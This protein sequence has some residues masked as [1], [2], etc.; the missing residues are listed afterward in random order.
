MSKFADFAAVAATL[1]IGLIGCAAS[2]SH[3]AT[4]Q[5]IVESPSLNLAQCEQINI[6]GHYSNQGKDRVSPN[7]PINSRL[8]WDL[9]H[10]F[11][12]DARIEQKVAFVKID[13]KFPNLID[14]IASDADGKTIAFANLSAEHKDYSCTNGKIVI[15][16]KYTVQ[17]EGSGINVLQIKLSKTAE[18][19]LELFYER[20]F[21]SLNY[22]VS[23]YKSRTVAN[24]VFRTRSSKK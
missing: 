4:E 14:M 19:D 17:S 3:N 16:R 5:T 12:L 9:N 11:R 23:P 18:G 15:I 20:H 6:S 22:V 2:E 13:Q 1:I 7:D 21:E 10:V 24:P 8:V